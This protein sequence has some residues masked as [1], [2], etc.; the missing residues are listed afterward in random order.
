M[1]YIFTALLIIG[2]TVF[3]GA[4]AMDAVQTEKVERFKHRIDFDRVLKA[5]NTGEAV[6]A[7]WP[8]AIDAPG[9]GAGWTVADDSIWRTNGGTVREWLLRRNDE[10][11]GVLIFVSEDGVESARQF[12]LFRASNNMMEDVPY[13]AGPRGL[14]TLAVQL[15]VAKAPSVLWVYR[16]TA[17]NVYARDTSVDILP[18][19]KWLQAIA[20][21]GLVAAAAAHLRAPGT[22][23]VSSRRAAVG[24]PINIAVALPP[25]AQANYEMKLEFD[26]QL[27]QVM[28]QSTFAAQVRGT[29]PGS[30]VLDLWLIE[31]NTLR[32][33]RSKIHLEFN[34]PG[35]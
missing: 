18:V 21:A 28:S 20:E 13:V 7:V 12:L 33:A 2:L 4:V 10:T 30:T 32:S 26:R 1:P 27:L 6:R 5:E 31:L 25:S 3:N 16:N 23:S 22:L 34:A 15:P 14:G 19:A 9:L 11:V 29:K 8:N 35:R 24:Q 17:F